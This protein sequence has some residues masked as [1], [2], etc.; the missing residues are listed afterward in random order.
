MGSNDYRQWIKITMFDRCFRLV[1]MHLQGLPRFTWSAPLVIFMASVFSICVWVT[2]LFLVYV[3]LQCA[4]P[5]PEESI[6]SR[7]CDLFAFKAFYSCYLVCLL[8]KSISN[9]VVLCRFIYCMAHTCCTPCTRRRSASARCGYT[10]HLWHTVWACFPVCRNQIN[11]SV[12]LDV[13]AHH[14]VT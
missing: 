13:N 10:M 1:L 5:A 9:V 14:Q 8:P 4:A 2:L 11:K 6:A 7:T 3:K 12:Y